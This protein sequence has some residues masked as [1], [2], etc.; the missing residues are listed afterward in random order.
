MFEQSPKEKLEEVR[1]KER[2]FADWALQRI[3]SR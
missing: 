3:L 2:Q 1:D